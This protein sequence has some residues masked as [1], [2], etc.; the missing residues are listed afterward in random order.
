MW[1]LG[2]YQ[3]TPRPRSHH[4]GKA[5][6]AVSP[7]SSL[8]SSWVGSLESSRLL[9]GRATCE[10]VGGGGGGVITEIHPALTSRKVSLDDTVLSAFCPTHHFPSA[11][12]VC[13]G[14]HTCSRVCVS[15]TCVLNSTPEI[16]TAKSHSCLFQWSWWKAAG[17]KSSAFVQ[18]FKA[19]SLYK[20]HYL[21]LWSYFTRVNLLK[22]LWGNNHMRHMVSSSTC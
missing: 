4:S 7:P 16:I 17:I 18:T 22:W 14:A 8:I 3:N 20:S 11:V 6:V 21:Y 15:G 10:P 9:L 12:L 5:N 19:K 2:E 1:T 13:E